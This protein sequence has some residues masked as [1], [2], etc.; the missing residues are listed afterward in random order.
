M[1]VQLKKFDHNKM[2]NR[3]NFCLRNVRLGYGI[4]PKWGTAKEAM[5]ENRN[6]GTLHDLNSIPTNVAVPVFTDSYPSQ[7][8]GHVI[9]CDHGIYYDDGK[10]RLKPNSTYKWGEILNGVI[11]VKKADDS[12][13]VGDSVRV[14]GQ[15]T[16][17]SDGRGTKTKSFNNRLMAVVDIK[18]GRYGC[19]QWNNKTGTITGWF[20]INQVT[21]G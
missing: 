4:D 3:K 11:V 19:N 15:G 16:S 5:Q 10:V 21:K 20:N 14:T 18:N 12:I 2:G 17:S 7:K 1:F 8:Y 9:V 6:K 13:K